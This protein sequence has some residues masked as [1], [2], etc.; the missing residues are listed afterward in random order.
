MKYIESLSDAWNVWQTVTMID[1][2]SVSAA[3]MVTSGLAAS[4]S[5]STANLFLLVVL[6]S[7]GGS[8]STKLLPGDSRGRF[9]SET[10]SYKT[11]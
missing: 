4:D 9:V 8:G 11:N 3:S 2:T 7:R 6:V 5:E 10:D 1:S